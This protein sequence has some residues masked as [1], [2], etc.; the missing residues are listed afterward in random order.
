[1]KKDS[2]KAKG[3][4]ELNKLCNYKMTNEI[5]DGLEVTNEG[6]NQAKQSQINPITHQY[7]LF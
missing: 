6:A 5:W 7:D 4:N 2:L 1:M 3:L